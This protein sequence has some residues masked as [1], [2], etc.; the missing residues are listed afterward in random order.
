MPSEV[1]LERPNFLRARR[2]AL[3]ILDTLGV[4]APPVDPVRLSREL[5]LSVYFVRF[6]GEHVKVSGFYDSEDNTIFVNSDEYP[7]R[8]TF[9]VAHELGH[10]VMH[11]EW[12]RS[13]D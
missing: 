6:S 13:A 10:Y 4:E 8:Q 12:A 1:V 7:L 3:S 9:T 5:G 11:K 2:E